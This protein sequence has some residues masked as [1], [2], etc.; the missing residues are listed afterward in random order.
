MSIVR[1][2]CREHNL[3]NIKSN[4]IF[5]RQ[6]HRAG[7]YTDSKNK[8]VIYLPPARIFRVNLRLEIICKGSP[9]Y[10]QGVLCI[11]TDDAA[12]SIGQ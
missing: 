5:I 9:Q 7:H 12:L 1:K 3:S 2:S 10:E 6:R 11:K 8:S 4:L